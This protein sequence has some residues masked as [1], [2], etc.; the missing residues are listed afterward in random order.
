M[1]MSFKAFING[2]FTYPFTMDT[3]SFT[4]RELNAFSLFLKE[5]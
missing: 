1:I 4:K 3:E 2:S 5:E